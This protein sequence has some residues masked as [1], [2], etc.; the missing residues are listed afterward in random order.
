MVVVFGS[1]LC[2]P[3]PHGDV[4]SLGRSAFW[5]VC[6][7]HDFFFLQRLVLV[8]GIENSDIYAKKDLLLLLT[9]WGVFL[10]K[11]LT[12]HSWNQSISGEA[13]GKDKIKV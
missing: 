5:G 8:E 6:S 11:L 12:L 1:G 2:H 7:W 10:E 13:I 4:C 9:L 3:V